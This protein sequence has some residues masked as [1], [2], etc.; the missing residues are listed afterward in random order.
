[1]RVLLIPMAL[2]VLATLVGCSSTQIA[3]KESLGYAKREQLVDRVEDARD[4]QEAAKQQFESA[5]AEFLSVTGVETGELEK[6]YA[7]IKKQYE[8]CEDRAKAVNA[9]IKDVERVATALFKEWNAELDQYS[10]SE[11]RAASKRQLDDTKIKYDA[12]L[13]T[14]KQAAAKMDPVLAAFKDQTLFLKHNLNAR[15][16][17]SLQQTSGQIQS[18]VQTLVAEMEQAINEANA[19]IQEMQAN[20]G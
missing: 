2:A 4:G 15:A 20:Q 1:M 16:I 10:S 3:V 9:R 17:A 14:M 12:L 13:S 19:F 5:L 7:S 18:D 6:K 11:M 8:R